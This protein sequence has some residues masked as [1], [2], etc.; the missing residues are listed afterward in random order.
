MFL[1]KSSNLEKLE[2]PDILILVIFFREVT[3]LS[4]GA[5]R[6]RSGIEKVSPLSEILLFTQRQR[7]NVQEV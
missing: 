2:I 3:D 5:D 7:R 1:T 6:E 4:V